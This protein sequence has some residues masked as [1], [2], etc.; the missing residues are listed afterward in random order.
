MADLLLTIGLIVVT[1][2]QILLDKLP[3]VLMAKHSFKLTHNKGTVMFFSL[4]LNY[5][6]TL[7]SSLFFVLLVSFFF[8]DLISSSHIAV[9]PIFE[10]METTW[11]GVAGKTWGAL[12]AVVQAGHLVGLGVLGGSVIASDGRLLGLFNSLPMRLVV[13]RCHSV[14]TWSLALLVATGIFMAC[15][16]AIKIYYMPVYWYKM[17]ALT[18]GV[19]FVFFIRKP[20]LERD[21]DQVS[22][23]VLRLLAT[24]S[25]MIWF[26]VAAT[27]RWIGFS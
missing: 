26:T 2:S 10:W 20:I 1:R 13:D 23:W 14:F 3:A 7:C 9:L 4:M 24:A 18:L 27:G 22:P 8:S 25:I 5:R 6:K 21:L 11:F 12:F 17:L 19:L 15:G 16:V